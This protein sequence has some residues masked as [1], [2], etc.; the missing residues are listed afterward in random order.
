MVEP[1]DG[2]PVCVWACNALG[3]QE[4][5]LAAPTVHNL[6]TSQVGEALQAARMGSPVMGYIIRAHS[7]GEVCGG[8]LD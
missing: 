4:A 5:R 3:N 7:T 1:R 2:V 6:I 8:L